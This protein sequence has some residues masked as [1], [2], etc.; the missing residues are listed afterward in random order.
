M[1]EMTGTNKVK[2]R[3]FPIWPFRMRR[4]GWTRWWL[5]LDSAY[6]KMPLT[7]CSE[8]RH[9]ECLAAGEC[10]QERGDPYGTDWCRCFT[11]T[12]TARD[13]LPLTA[14]MYRIERDNKASAEAGKEKPCR[15]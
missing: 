13:R 4:R 2:P 7:L 14:G 5:M 15:R 11:V 3:W 8:K 12:V 9:R 10:L 6:P 1:P